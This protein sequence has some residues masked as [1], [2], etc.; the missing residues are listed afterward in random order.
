MLLSAQ[1][2]KA[3]EVDGV[4]FEEY[5]ENLEA[6]IADLVIQMRRFSLRLQP[7]RR[8]YIPKSNGKQRPLGIPALEDKIV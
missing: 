5:E 1:K 8:V 7:V 4:T 3:S 2:G 6:N